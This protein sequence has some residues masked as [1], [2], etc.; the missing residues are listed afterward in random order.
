MSISQSCFFYRDVGDNVG[1]NVFFPSS[2]INIMLFNIIRP[3]GEEE[4][5]IKHK[6]Y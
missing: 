6:F 1:H 5:N 4:A 3:H 2:V